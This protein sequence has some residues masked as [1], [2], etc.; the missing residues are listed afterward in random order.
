MRVVHALSEFLFAILLNFLLS[1]PVSAETNG[2]ILFMSTR[3]G[4]LTKV[5]VMDPDGRNVRRLGS[6]PGLHN[7]PQF[8]HDNRKILFEYSAETFA[9]RQIYIMNADGSGTKALTSGRESHGGAQFT[10]DDRIV[11]YSGKASYIMDMDGS[12]NAPFS[13]AAPGIGT[14]GELGSFMFGPKGMVVFTHFE[15]VKGLFL[16]QIFKVS[17]DGTGLVRLVE[18]PETYRLPSWCSDGTRIAYVNAGLTEFP[19]PP[20]HERDGI[21]QMSASGTNAVRIVEVDFSRTVGEHDSLGAIGAIGRGRETVGLSREPSF[22]RDCKM[23]T[24]SLNLD[25]QDQVYVVNS[26]GSGMRRLTGPPGMN[27]GPVFSH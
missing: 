15:M 11:Y 22:S 4:P 25:R 16:E 19:I 9:D 20:R 26:D 27:G 2:R 10:W 12:H 17:T 5:Y 6:L 23:L 21:Y 18:S 24:F 14:V 13:V 7:R 3:D 1:W 8:S